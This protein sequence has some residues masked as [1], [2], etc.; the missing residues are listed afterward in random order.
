MTDIGTV[1]LQIARQLSFYT[2]ARLMQ[3]RLVL[4]YENGT[5]TTQMEPLRKFVR[6][7]LR[8]KGIRCVIIIIRDS[9]PRDS[10]YRRGRTASGSVALQEAFLRAILPDDI[11]I[12]SIRLPATSG[13]TEPEVVD[14]VRE[15]LATAPGRAM[16]VSTTLDRMLRRRKFYDE[17]RAI[18]ADGG[19]MAMSFL[20]DTDTQPL[21]RDAVLVGQEV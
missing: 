16:L 12:M 1:G 15:A 13:Y 6:E 11:H 2:R 5:D 8:M 4:A 10:D 18:L 14:R 17:L 19:H 7:L 20:W 21:L 9:P 3:Q